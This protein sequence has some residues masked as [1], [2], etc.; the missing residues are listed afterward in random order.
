MRYS[1]MRWGGLE[2]IGDVRYPKKM[3][4]SSDEW[5]VMAQS[6]DY[7]VLRKLRNAL[8]PK[9]LFRIV[10]REGEIYE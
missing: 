6:N 10:N 1:L 3:M 2:G 8:G 7:N 4:K 5:V 9:E